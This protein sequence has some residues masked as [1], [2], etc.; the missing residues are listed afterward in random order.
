MKAA[1]Y[2]AVYTKTIKHNGD[3]III[4]WYQS[5][6]SNKDNELSLTS[7]SNVPNPKDV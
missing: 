2:T 7:F 4:L 3:T 1:D 6:Y 5:T